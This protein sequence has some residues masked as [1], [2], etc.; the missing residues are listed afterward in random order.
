MGSYANHLEVDVDSLI[1]SK[2]DG[3][4]H[5]GEVNTSRTLGLE[6]GNAILC[7]P[8]QGRQEEDANQEGAVAEEEQAEESNNNN[9]TTPSPSAAKIMISI[10]Y[11]DGPAPSEYRIS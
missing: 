5:I 8:L 9:T 7:T 11:Q 10:K 2:E 4:T 6:D 3:T 1:F